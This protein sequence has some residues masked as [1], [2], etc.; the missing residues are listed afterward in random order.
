[1]KNTQKAND[2]LQVEIKL[3]YGDVKLAQDEFTAEIRNIWVSFKHE[4]GSVWDDMKSNQNEFNREIGYVQD[5]MKHEMKSTWD[6]FNRK[7]GYIQTDLDSLREFT[8]NTVIKLAQGIDATHTKTMK[9]MEDKLQQQ[10]SHKSKPT[11][12]DAVR[13]SD[14]VPPDIKDIDI[15]TQLTTATSILKTALLATASKTGSKT[16][17]F[18]ATVDFKEIEC[19][20][21][22][23]MKTAKTNTHKIDNND[24]N[25]FGNCPS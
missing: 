7:N 21:K 20:S 22:S 17:H 25:K 5:N 23:R 11:P 19:N 12:K 16:I 24:N 1:M 15:V 13:Q 2:N 14:I 6:K 4:I 18:N 3:A 9:S 10:Q 8:Q